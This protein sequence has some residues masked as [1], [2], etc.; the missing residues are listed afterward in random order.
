LD[1][2]T[3]TA[4]PVITVAR[5]ACAPIPLAIRSVWPWITCTRR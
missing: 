3:W 1:A 4:D 5:E 2:A